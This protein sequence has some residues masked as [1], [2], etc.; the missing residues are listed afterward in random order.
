MGVLS[1]G[2]NEG[3]NEGDGGFSGEEGAVDNRSN[4]VDTA[5]N[6]SEQME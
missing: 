2:V 6:Q 1:G 4:G 5:D 3:V